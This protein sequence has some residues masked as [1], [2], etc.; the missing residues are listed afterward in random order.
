MILPLSHAKGEYGR[1]QCCQIRCSATVVLSSFD[2][3]VTSLQSHHLR[4]H[5]WAVGSYDSRL[6]IFDARNPARPIIDRD[7]LDV[8]GGIWRV[9]WH[10]TDQSKL[11]IAA[12]HGGFRVVNVPLLDEGQLECVT[13]F[14]EHQ[15]IA[16]GCDWDYSPKYAKDSPRLVC[17]ASFYDARMHIWKA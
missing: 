1:I 17:S 3:G 6:R 9:K 10:P 16:Y 7:G 12:M 8:G 15:S 5:I 11:L 4:Q 14:D 2:G 13:S